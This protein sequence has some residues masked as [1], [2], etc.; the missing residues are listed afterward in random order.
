MFFRTNT[1]SILSSS[2]SEVSTHS[3]SPNDRPEQTTYC[4]FFNTDPS[5]HC[6]NCRCCLSTW[7]P[8]SP[9]PARWHHASAFRW[10]WSTEVCLTESQHVFIMISPSFR[11]SLESHPMLAALAFTTSSLT[12][13]PLAGR[14]RNCWPTSRIQHSLRL[15]LLSLLCPRFSRPRASECRGWS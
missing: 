13:S 11:A 3:L 15:C 14:V 6:Y 12:T 9:L 10:A 4:T 1:S 5:F 7:L 8:A 2:F